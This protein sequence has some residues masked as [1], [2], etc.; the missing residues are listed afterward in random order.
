MTLPIRARRELLRLAGR[1]R[2][3]I[4]E[5]ATYHELYFTE[6]PP[7][8]LR[9][10]DAHDIVIYLNSF[11]KVLAPGLRLGWLSAAPSIV[12][13]IAIIKQ[14]LDP[15]TQNLVQFAMA[16]LIRDGSFDNHLKTLRA[17]HARRCALMLASIQR[18]VPPGA[19]RFARPQGGLYLWCRLASGICSRELLERA[20]AAGVAF[21]PGH[22]FYPD[23]AGESELRICFSSVLPSAIDDAVRRLASSLLETARASARDRRTLVPVA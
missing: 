6:A 8:S 19:I 11:S 7:P 22:A 14:R 13:Q 17:E 5:D 12:D 18:H 1:Y 2:V 20:L 10:L 16:R 15:H 4:V 23:P 3:P 21:V 9:E